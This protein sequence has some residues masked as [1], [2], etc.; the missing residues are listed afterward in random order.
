M[1]KKLRGKVANVLPILRQLRQIRHAVRRIGDSVDSLRRMEGFRGYDEMMDAHPR[2]SDPLRLHRYG[3]Q[4]NS[5]N[6][7]DGLIH[8]ILKRIGV[9]SRVFVEVGVGDGTENNTAFLLSLGWS[10]F[11]IDGSDSF[12]K[13]LRGR[14]DLSD[15][16]LKTAVSFV[17]RENIAGVFEQLGVPQEMDL[18]SLDIDQNTYYLWEGLRAYSPRVV[19]VE[20]NANI[21][22]DIDWKVKYAADRTWDSTHNFGASLKAFELLGAEL[23]YSLVGCD[24]IGAN[25]FFVRQDLAEGKF[26]EPFTAANHFEPPRYESAPRR[27]HPRSILDRQG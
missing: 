16:C 19:V 5:Q 7:E 11:W 8:E 15:G 23:G 4:V 25:A 2:Y 9:S 10:G 13:N 1:F 24:F 17:D 14:D 12:Q 26:A 6:Y 22:P 3:F 27:G 21:P 18:L 20:Y